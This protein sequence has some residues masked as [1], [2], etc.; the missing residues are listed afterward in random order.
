MTIFMHAP[1][2]VVKKLA[3]RADRALEKMRRELESE[4]SD[5]SDREDGFDDETGVIDVSISGLALLECPCVEIS[6]CSSHYG[7]CW[8]RHAVVHCAKHGVQAQPEAKPLW[9]HAPLPTHRDP[10]DGV[11]CAC[12]RVVHWLYCARITVTVLSSPCCCFLLQAFF[13]ACYFVSIT[14]VAKLQA[15]HVAIAYGQQRLVTF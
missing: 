5:D 13:I 14:A 4:A 7:C 11:L 6:C 2:N 12:L 8:N 3:Q 1:V 15:G 9:L 10:I